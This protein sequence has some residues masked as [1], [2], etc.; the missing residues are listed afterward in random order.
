M[1]FSFSHT[2][3]ANARKKLFENTFFNSYSTATTPNRLTDMQLFLHA[4]H[5]QSRGEGWR[6]QCNLVATFLA[7]SSP[8]YPVYFVIFFV[9]IYF[10]LIILFFLIQC[11]FQYMFMFKNLELIHEKNTKVGAGGWKI[12]FK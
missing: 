5:R 3:N 7:Y 11:M 9:Y 2:C 12:I 1:S 4:W 6:Q 10:A 8:S